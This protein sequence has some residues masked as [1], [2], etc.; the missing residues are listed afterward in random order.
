[1]WQR[2]LFVPALAIAALASFAFWR[3]MG[4]PVEL[5]DVPGGRLQCLSY[6]PFEPKLIGYN[7]QGIVGE[8][9]IETD[10]AALAPLT[11]CIR[12]YSALDPARDIVQA[13]QRHGIKVLLGAWIGGRSQAKQNQQ[14]IDEALALAQRY[15]DTVSALI[16]GNEVL[17]RREMTA[18]QLA[19]LIR[20]V[21]AQSPVPVAYADVDHFIKISPEVAA[22]VDLALIHILPYW[23]DPVAPDIDE[24]MPYV[25]KRVA[26]FRALYPGTAIMIGETGWPSEGRRRGRAQPSLLNEARYVRTF[27]SRAEA[28]GLR[29][30]LI[31]AI[32]QPW[33]R[34]PEGTVG[35]HWGVLDQFRAQKFPLT[36]PVSEWP[37]W[38]GAWG[39]S[40]AAAFAVLLGGVL[41]RGTAITGWLGL[42]GLATGLGLALPL[43]WHFIATTSQTTGGWAARL[44]GMALTLASVAVL[45]R[46][47]TGRAV[48]DTVPLAR[49]WPVF[50]AA[51]RGRE[52]ISLPLGLLHGATLIVA[53]YI[54]INLAL[55]PRHLDIPTVLFALPAAALFTR[56]NASRPAVDQREEALL[57]TIILT[58][59]LL[60]IE[61]ANPVTWSWAAVCVLLGLSQRT[62]LRSELLRL[63][64]LALEPREAQQRE[65]H[66]ER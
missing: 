20:T 48:P 42:T 33:K 25:E 61:L 36:G 65:Q 10:M 27:A 5:P 55:A 18:A 52:P 53:A 11:G 29:Y 26:E 35:G 16:V 51:G 23:N 58:C 63:R 8:E 39:V 15:P 66:A 21:K 24:V 46:R 22:A 50:N 62:A 9:R 37:G 45:A 14:Q 49:L 30:N 12:V 43:Q 13:A 7:P 54:S 59:G 6:T 56:S 38:R 1:M 57:S 44:L 4:A 64:R 41:R 47:L 40:V 3:W 34:V 2:L 31:E 19:G 60:Q 28:Q 17:L 32:D